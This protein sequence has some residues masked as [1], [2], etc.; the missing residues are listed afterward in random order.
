[1][2]P[3]SRNL[4]LKYLYETSYRKGVN[5][6]TFNIKLGAA[7]AVATFVASVI[8]PAGLA[9]TGITI[10][11]NGANS[12]SNVTVNNTSNVSVNQTNDST[13]VTD[14]N[15]TAS[16]GGNDASFNTGGDTSIIT[17]NASS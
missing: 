2:I 15:S 17:G 4:Q 5:Y 12:T 10:V 16:T 14:V 11:G 1:M 9:D 8:A 6:M 13:I 7:V 3:Y